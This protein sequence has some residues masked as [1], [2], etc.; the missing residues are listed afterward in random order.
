[1]DQRYGPDHTDVVDLITERDGIC[2]MYL[3]EENELEGDQLL[4]LQE[5]LNSYLS[6]VL[7][8]QL[9]RSY[10]ALAN[11][12]KV[13]RIS[14]QHTPSEF[15]GEFLQRVKSAFAEYDVGLEFVIERS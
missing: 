2:Y 7:D 15:T 8:G 5:K 10:P 13:I 4:A 3:I 12:Q 1:M 11:L 14:L 6:F 9:Q